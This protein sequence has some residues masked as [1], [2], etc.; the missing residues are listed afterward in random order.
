M[1]ELWLKYGQ[2]SVAVDIKY[3][4]LLSHLCPTPSTYLSEE[5]IDDELS[6]MEISDNTIFVVLSASEAVLRLIDQISQKLV[7]SNCA[8]LASRSN[9]VKILKNPLKKQ[10]YP[11]YDAS[12]ASLF[13]LLKRYK[14]VVCISQARYDP[15][16]GYS[17]TPTLFLRQFFSREMSEAFYSRSNNLP[18]PCKKLSPLE[19]ALRTV[20]NLDYASIEVVGSPKIFS[21]HHGDISQ[22]FES[23]TRSLDNSQKTVPGKSQITLLSPGDDLESHLTLCSSLDS[24]WNVIGHVKEGGLAALLSENSMG[25]GCQAL[26]MFVEDRFNV[27][28]H[29]RD[30][31][32]YIEGLEHILFLEELGK[33]YDLGIISTLPEY[34]LVKL[35]FITFKSSRDCYARSLSKYGRSQKILVISGADIMSLK[36]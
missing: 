12:H 1:P 4:N 16:F 31:L 30:S 14:N 22:S 7:L 29:L 15:L 19:I 33:N 6:E 9:I 17:G 21:L 34:Y 27:E 8:C 25:L 13:P 11:V 26:E 32:Q 36:D 2:T 24:L 20:D 28:N 5:Q 3:E 10:P 23:A 35:G 18:N